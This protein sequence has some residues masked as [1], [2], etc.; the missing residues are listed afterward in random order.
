MVAS[1][2]MALAIPAQANLVENGSFENLGGGSFNSEDWGL[3]DSVPGW[4]SAN[5][6]QLEIGKASVYGVTGQVG[7]NVMEL[8]S[9]ANV[10]SYQDLDTIPGGSYTLSFL[11]E[12][13]SALLAPEKAESDQ[14]RVLWNGAQ[15]GAII[16]PSSTVMTSW[17]WQVTALGDGKDVLTFEG[18]GNSDSY[19]AL[20]DGVTVVPEPT[21]IVAG[22]LLLLPFGLSAVRRSRK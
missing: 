22:A 6:V 14:F 7:E 5:G 10:V 19:G 8:D 16:D 1:M 11:Y 17:S 4:N 15:I 12:T 20:V 13:R 18:L 3:F 2:A 9:T 21:T